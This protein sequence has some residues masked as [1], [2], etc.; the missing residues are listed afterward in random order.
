[1][2]VFAAACRV[3]QQTQDNRGMRLEQTLKCSDDE[4]CAC[5]GTLMK[6]LPI[7]SES[8]NVEVRERGFTSH[9]LLLSIG[10]FPA[11]SNAN[12]L[13]IEAEHDTASIAAKCRA[14]SSM[15]TYLLVPEPMKPI[16]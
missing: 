12:V 6:H 7:F 3:N 1:M 2:K 14:S 8:P 13:S 10:L 4:L 15:L 9:Q 11:G 5:V 16:S